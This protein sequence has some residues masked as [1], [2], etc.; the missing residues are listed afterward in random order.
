MRH[1]R[2]VALPPH[3]LPPYVSPQHAFATCLRTVCTH[4]PLR[5]TPVPTQY[6]NSC[7]PVKTSCT[8]LS[9]LPAFAFGIANRFYPLPYRSIPRQQCSCVFLWSMQWHVVLV[10][11]GVLYRTLSRTS[12][13]KVVF[14][15]FRKRSRTW[16]NINFQTKRRKGL[17]SPK[18]KNNKKKKQRKH[19]SKKN[20]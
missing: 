16:R 8:V 1:L 13:C 3:Y 19:K 18:K 6:V 5:T 11:C 2:T 20:K 7:C 12:L 4:A 14:N 15:R 17:K 9:H 10:T